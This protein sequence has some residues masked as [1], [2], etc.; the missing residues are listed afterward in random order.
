MA[1][2]LIRLK[3]NTHA[4]P[5]KDRMMYKRGDIVVVMPDGHPWGISEALPDFAVIRTDRAV[6][7]MEQ[8]LVVHEVPEV[9]TRE[10]D[11]VEW[12]ERKAK[13]DHGDFIDLPSEGKR[14]KR[15]DREKKK[16]VPTITLTGHVMRSHTRRRWGVVLGML[17]SAKFTALTGNGRAVIPFTQLRIA[18]KDKITGVKA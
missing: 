1:E 8:F 12:R 10:I 5:A 13:G 2:L 18:L 15:Y 14:G 9:E 7:R 11:A 17:P 6:A 3:N 4:Y 16:D